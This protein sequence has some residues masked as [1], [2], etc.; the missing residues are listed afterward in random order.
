MDKL[1]PTLH[2]RRS[3]IAKTDFRHRAWRTRRIGADGLRSSAAS[4]SRGFIAA[5]EDS[6]CTGDIFYGLH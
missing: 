3:S 1:W 5:A 4:Q 2:L 6:Y